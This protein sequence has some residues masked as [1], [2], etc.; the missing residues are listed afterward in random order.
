MLAHRHQF[1]ERHI[2]EVGGKRAGL[3]PP[4]DSSKVTS[5]TSD[6]VRYQLSPT[7]KEEL[8]DIWREQVQ[9]KFGFKNYENLRQALKELS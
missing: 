4:I 8:D 1:N 6:Q 7:L 5:G 3:P 9:P 2:H